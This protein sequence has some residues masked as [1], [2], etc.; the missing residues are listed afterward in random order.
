MEKEANAVEHQRCYPPKG[1]EPQPPTPW[2]ATG[3]RSLPPWRDHTP[4][5]T[6]DTSY[7]SYKGDLHDY[8]LAGGCS[9]VAGARGADCPYRWC[10]RHLGRIQHGLLTGG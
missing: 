9:W 6:L 1:Q 10:L 5:W 2:T 4:I 3:E 8:G 7:L